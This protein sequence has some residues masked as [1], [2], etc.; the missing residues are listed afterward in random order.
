MKKKIYR[1]S[2]LVVVLTVAVTALY[3]SKSDLEGGAYMNVCACGY[4][5]VRMSEGVITL[6]E[7]NHE[8]KIGD[9]VG[10]YDSAG[11]NVTVFSG[12]NQ[13]IVSSTHD[14]LGLRTV[15]PSDYCEYL[16][17]THTWKACIH[18]LWRRLN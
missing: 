17:Y 18:G 7:P 8:S 3:F 1:C 12:T 2:L 13:F 5:R 11:T 10:R 15:G 9:I 14:Y 4:A 16:I 6:A